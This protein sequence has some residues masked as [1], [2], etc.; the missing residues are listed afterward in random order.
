[1]Q[2]N[3][4]VQQQST[5]V[6]SKELSSKSK[7]REWTIKRKIELE[8]PDIIAETPAKTNI[9]NIITLKDQHIANKR[10]IFDGLVKNINQQAFAPIGLEMNP[11]DFYPFVKLATRADLTPYK[12]VTAQLRQLQAEVGKLQGKRD[13]YPEN[14][15]FNDMLQKLK[16]SKTKKNDISIITQQR[17]FLSELQEGMKAYPMASLFA[18]YYSLSSIPEKQISILKEAVNYELGN[19]LVDKRN[20]IPAVRPQTITTV[21]SELTRLK[22]TGKASLSAEIDTKES[23]MLSLKTTISKAIQRLVETHG[24][25]LINNLLEEEEFV[26]IKN[27]IEK[28]NIKIDGFILEL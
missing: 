20:L 27:T 16:D 24:A 5:T 6:Q 8:I 17:N 9:E 12:H 23:K 18:I 13:T 2:Q 19:P 3:S 10:E 15:I 28:F 25:A 1:M 7:G 11:L 14:T 26:D 21:E 4:K 22:N